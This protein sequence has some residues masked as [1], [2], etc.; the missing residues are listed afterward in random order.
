M[1]L[2]FKNRDELSDV[3]TRVLREF[4]ERDDLLVEI[5]DHPLVH[6]LTLVDLARKVLRRIAVQINAP[7]HSGVRASAYD[8][9][10]YKILY[11]SHALY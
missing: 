8:I 3:R 11:S 4:L 7:V 9:E 2:C 1:T 5:L 6:V 10:Q